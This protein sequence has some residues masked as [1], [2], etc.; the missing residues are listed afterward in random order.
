MAD[1]IYKHTFTVV[2]LTEDFTYD[3]DIETL[4]YDITEGDYIGEIINVKTIVVPADKVKD[5]LVA[6]GND[7]TYFDLGEDE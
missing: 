2:V 3:P 7:G 1:P 4:A 6:I 5:E